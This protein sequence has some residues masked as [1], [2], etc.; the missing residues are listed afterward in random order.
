MILLKVQILDQGLD[1][2]KGSFSALS[3]G[4]NSKAPKQWKSPEMS[5]PNRFLPV[6]I[7]KVNTKS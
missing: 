6:L 2:S 4:E 1:I 3:K 5:K 7:Q